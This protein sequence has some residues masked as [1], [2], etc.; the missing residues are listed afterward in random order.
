MH[1]GR[2]MDRTEKIRQIRIAGIAAFPVCRFCLPDKGK[3]TSE[4]MPFP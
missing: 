4:E 3:D 2:I 1:R